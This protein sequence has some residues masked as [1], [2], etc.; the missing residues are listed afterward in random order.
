MI[1]EPA[2]MCYCVH[3]RQRGA[4]S[5][6]VPLSLDSESQHTP[7]QFTQSSETQVRST[8]GP[9]MMKAMRALSLYAYW[10]CRLAYWVARLR[11]YL[12][13]YIRTDKYVYMYGY[14]WHTYVCMYVYMCQCA[15][16]VW[17]SLP[18]PVSMPRPL[19]RSLNTCYNQQRKLINR[20]WPLKI[21]SDDLIDSSSISKSGV[22]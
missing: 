5:G 7:I 13:T 6:Y 9:S 17:V 21:D 12:H 15:I 16:Q 20:F 19:R 14:V 10:V 22:D 11:V 2:G 8:D 3:S 1:I 18:R 4:M